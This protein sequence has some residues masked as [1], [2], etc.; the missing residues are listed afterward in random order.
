MQE[1]G[2]QYTQRPAA[3]R[4]AAARMLSTVP[5]YTVGVNPAVRHISTVN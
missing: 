1:D 4:A 5:P 3:T 2:T